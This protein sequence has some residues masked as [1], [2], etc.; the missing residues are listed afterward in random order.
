MVWGTPLNVQLVPEVRVVL[1]QLFPLNF[2][3][4]Q[5]LSQWAQI[6]PPESEFPGVTV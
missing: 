6:H 2:V 4:G 1:C 5:N 3:V